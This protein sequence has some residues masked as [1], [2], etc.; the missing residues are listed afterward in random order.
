MLSGDI[1]EELA[2]SN[3]LAIMPAMMDLVGV[4][5]SALSRMA[6]EFGR[7]FVPVVVGNHGRNTRKPRFKGRVFTNF[8]WLIGCFLERHFKAIGDDRVRFHIP[9]ESDAYFTVY[10]HRFLLTHGDCLGVKGG[11]GIIGALGPILR[12]SMKV[13]RSS[14]DLG[15][16]YDT[17]LMGHWHQHI[18][19]HGVVVNGAL[20]GYDE[21]AKGLRFRPEPPSQA[22]LFVSPKWGITVPTRIFVDAAPT[23]AA[24]TAWTSWAA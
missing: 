23:V 2:E 3:E 11:D 20:K 22:L 24:P 17:L 7:V 21:F 19:V 14:A 1:H 12:G 13:N 4:L 5:I 6:D 16:P 10:G 8:D 9:A 15:R 18:A